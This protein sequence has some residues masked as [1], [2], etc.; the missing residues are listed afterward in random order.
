[1]S[2]HDSQPKFGSQRNPIRLE[3]AVSSS[4]GFPEN[5]VPIAPAT[6]RVAVAG[7]PERRA[8]ELYSSDLQIVARATQ[9]NE[10]PAKRAADDSGISPLSPLEGAILL[11]V[12][13]TAVRMHASESWVRRHLAQL[14][15]VPRLGGM[16]RIDAKRLDDLLTMENWKSLKP[17]GGSMR[18][19]QRGGVRLRGKVWY[20]YY[21]T[22]LPEGGR[23]GKEIRIGTKSELP[24]KTAARKKLAELMEQPA[25]PGAKQ[26]LT[27]ADVAKQWE[28]SE[29]PGIGKTSRKHYVDALRAYVLPTLGERSLDSIQRQDI[30]GLLSDK[31][32]KYSESSL[33]S[34]RLVCQMVL[35]YAER[36]SLIVRPAGWL[37][38]IRLPR[39]H[40]GRKIVRTQLEPGQTLAIIGHLREPYATLALFLAMTGK[41]G[42]E[43]VGI[44]PED[45]DSDN[46]LHIRR[47]IYDGRLE[48][49]ER[50]ELVPLDSPEHAELIQRMRT[51]GEG[52][53]WVFHNRRKDTPLNLGNA[54][55]R[56][57]QPAAKKA[58]VHIG[59]WHDFRHALQSKLRRGGV[60]P[61]VRAGVMGHSRVELG[62]EVYDKAS[63]DEKRAALTL[64]AKDLQANV[65][66]NQDGGD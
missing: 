2:P 59:G 19:F 53:K 61:V 66:A 32:P 15:V 27:F 23:K 64:V 24:T 39:E 55:R 62:P 50:E 41:R 54:R 57:L 14:P 46:I 49:L 13:E 60:D 17:I 12:A 5:V 11:T 42:E 52:H 20:G 37:D 34:M 38:G 21:R 29:G 47:V 4:P 10:G 31:A 22:D 51:L 8:G 36:N 35:Q 7:T 25:E 3:I 63:L 65:Q 28:K 9:Q 56:Y 48:D 6:A 18:R 44:Q 16:I 1:M 58:G 33:K 26:Q 43:A 45:L 30:T 40:G